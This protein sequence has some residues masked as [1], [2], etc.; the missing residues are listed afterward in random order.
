MN[1]NAILLSNFHDHIPR[2]MKQWGMKRRSDDSPMVKPVVL[3]PFPDY[4]KKLSKQ[5][6]EV[7]DREFNAWKLRVPEKSTMRKF[8]MPLDTLT[9][10]DASAITAYM[11]EDADKV[12]SSTKGDR[13]YTLLD[14]LSIKCAPQARTFDQLGEKVLRMVRQRMRGF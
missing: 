5:D 1:Y 10:V 9:E 2:M 8:S 14:N 3:D 7:W 11:Y 13:L 12:V 4:K 6:T